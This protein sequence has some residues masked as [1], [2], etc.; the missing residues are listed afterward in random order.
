[1]R[2]RMPRS[3]AP[4]VM[5]FLVVMPLEVEL[6]AEA[7]SADVP[8]SARPLD[9]RRSQYELDMAVG[10]GRFA[11]VPESCAPEPPPVLEANHVDGAIAV[12]K[13]SRDGVVLGMRGGWIHDEVA[14]PDSLPE[15]T[16]SERDIAYL[17]P[18][19]GVEKYWFGICAG[20]VISTEKFPTA[21]ADEERIPFSAGL[22]AGPP[23]IH[24]FV[25]IMES[26]P[27]QS[28]GGYLRLGLGTSRPGRYDVW[29]GVASEPHDESGL[30]L[31]AEV[32]VAPSVSVLARARLGESEDIKENSI[33]GGVR[34]HLGPPVD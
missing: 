7:D 22:R 24:A 5:G 32:R 14:D 28:G 33:A 8:E 16:S 27:L 21:G 9:T 31:G 2:I 17:N 34:F 12:T 20:G 23:R 13:R 3:A 1:M 26:V 11:I 19:L 30:A 18:W 4:V 6:P 25:S 29:A 15:G 10:G